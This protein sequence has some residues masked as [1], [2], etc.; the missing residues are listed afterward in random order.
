MLKARIKRSSRTKREGIGGDGMNRKICDR[1]IVWLFGATA[2]TPLLATAA[3]A[4]SRPDGQLE[5]IIVTAQKREESVQN[6]P[7]SISVISSAEL[8]NRSVQQISDLQSATPNVTFSTTAQGVFATTVGIRGLRNVN[9]ELVNDQPAA[10]YIDDVYQSTAIGSMAF[11]G[12]DVERIEVLRGPQGTL[13]GRNTIGGAV[14]IH[15]ARPDTKE[16]NGR[17][18]AGVGTSGIIEGQGMVNIPLVQDVM[19]ARFNIGFR[20]NDGYAKDTTYGRRLGQSKQIYLRGQL[21]IT[22]NDALDMLLSGD[23]VQTSSEGTLVQ[24]VFLR[25]NSPAFFAAGA[26]YGIAPTAANFAAIQARFFS[27]GG[28][29]RPTLGDRC[30]SPN[31]TNPAQ[32]TGL[33]KNSGDV[34][35]IA[36]YHEWGVSGNISYQLTDALQIKSI[37]AYRSFVM[38][39]PKDYDATI[40]NVLFSSNDPKGNTFTQELQLGG[41][42]L[43]DRLKFTLGAY[44]YRFNGLERGSNIALPGLVPAGTGSN[45]IQND[46]LNKSLGLFG[47]ATFA[48]TD[49]LN[50]TGGIRHTKEE[51]NAAISQFGSSTAGPVCTLPI[52]NASCV[53]ALTLKYKSWDWTGGLDYQLTDSVMPYFRAAKGFQA[54]GI[55]QRS[56]PGVPFKTYAP[57]T[58]INYELG[59]KADLF[60]RHVRLNLS[61]F[62]TDVK[63]FQRVIPATFINSQGASVSV[64]ATLN[65]ASARIRGFEG[66]LTVIPFE[67]A[68]I[69]GQVGY[70]NPKWN[71]FFAD[72][73]NG[74]GTLDLSQSDFQSISNWTFGASPS[75]TLP[76][77][78]GE[79]HFQLD[80][81]Y[82]SRVNLA[83]ALSFPRDQELP[84]PGLI[85]KGFGLLNG[86]IAARLSGGTEIAVWVKNLAD[87]RY[88][89]SGL[90]L[91]ASLGMANANVGD[92]RTAGIQV[93]HK[94]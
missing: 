70:T 76:T 92:P 82:Q 83:P 62:Q 22:P 4:Q 3:L 13:F 54:G 44:Y 8:Q 78:F 93:S 28:G 65:A 63:N 24:P 73:P 30:L 79:M 42:L 61:A 23:Y 6:V 33:F 72:G 58:A 90:N 1:R 84:V 41:Q 18:M 69:S 48:V 9:I 81:V 17:V 49:R 34:G 67:N 11:L 56:A 60:D 27:C 5:D 64:V 52:V 46:V 21:R 7:I 89:T 19:A 71:R 37:T 85:Q 25:P 16:F 29:P 15:T 12:P 45:Y 94:F 68:R 57:M 40:V 55:N 32:T 26:A 10:I 77:S 86:R 35:A 36:K 91:A 20:D 14:S 87:K 2:L 74:P 80:Y 88:F 51:K 75:Y 47:Q 38:R 43:D 39:G 31:L 53:N 59:M 66:E 50:V